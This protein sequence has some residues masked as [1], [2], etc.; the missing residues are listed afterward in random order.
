MSPMRL[1]LATAFVVALGAPSVAHA[2]PSFPGAIQAHLGGS[3]APPCR[4]CHVDGV[5]GFGTVNTPFGK[6]M[7]ARGLVAYDE[8]TLTAALDA[9]GKEGID[10][11]G[12]RGTPDVDVLRE[13]LDPNRANPYDT[14]AP[15]QYG[16][17][18]RF[19]RSDAARPVPLLLLAALALRGLSRGARGSARRT[20]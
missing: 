1:A 5:T 14:A 15:A 10:S 19:A 13:G 11:S 2:T 7:R 8:P 20:R 17:A 12:G 3:A 6:N 9:M 16:C 18:A 4:V